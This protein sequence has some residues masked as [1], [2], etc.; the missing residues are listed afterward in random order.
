MGVFD[1]LKESVLAKEVNLPICSLPRNTPLDVYYTYYEGKPQSHRLEFRRGQRTKF[2]MLL[3]H[4]AQNIL[5]LCSVLDS[6]DY[7]EAGGGVVLGFWPRFAL[8]MTGGKIISC[9][10]LFPGP[11]SEIHT[12][13][14]QAS[15]ARR[16]RFAYCRKGEQESVVLISSR[17]GRQSSTYRKGQRHEFNWLRLSL[18]EFTNLVEYLRSFVGGKEYYEIPKE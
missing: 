7:R 2:E 1:S 15:I 6:Q 16:Y 18:E 14:R 3:P 10:D 8:R 4:Y 11:S 5:Q 13:S 12:P 9:R 17:H